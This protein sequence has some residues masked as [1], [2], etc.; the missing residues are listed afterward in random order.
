M[1]WLCDPKISYVSTNSEHVWSNITT[2]VHR[3]YNTYKLAWKQILNDTFFLP[4]V[5][6][7]IFLSAHLPH[8]PTLY[9]PLSFPYFSSLTPNQSLIKT[10]ST[11]TRST[12]IFCNILM[13][14]SRYSSCNYI[15][16]WWTLE[17]FHVKI[18]PKISVRKKKRRKK[19][20]TIYTDVWLKSALELRIQ[21]ENFLRNPQL[22]TFSNYSRFSEHFLLP[23][24]TVISS[25]LARY[26][27]H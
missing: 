22:G 19:R 18:V 26:S 24:S 15:Y 14:V 8:S 13:S 25:L 12:I 4:Q 1:W 27:V 5:S 23:P 6:T 17:Y 16:A 10:P 11:A 21:S 20:A 9:S 7:A 2:L 3:H